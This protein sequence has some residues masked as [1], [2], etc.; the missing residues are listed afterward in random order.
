[1]VTESWN[2]GLAVGRSGGRAFVVQAEAPVAEVDLATFQVRSHP[3]GPGAL[4]ADAVA[5]PEREALWLGGGL[6]AVTGLDLQSSADEPEIRETP[7]GLT[8]VDT[9]RWRART[10]DPRTTDA[11]LVSGTLLASSFFFDSRRQTTSR[12]GLTGCSVDGSR[13]FH[14]YGNAPI[15]GVQPL[16]SKALVGVQ[17]GT[18]LIDARTGR[19]LRRYPRFTVSLLSGDAPVSY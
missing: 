9:R 17:D 7:A 18:V 6:L 3:L 4:A 2:P 5:G 16:G 19:Q 11:A 14:L 8:L 15:T 12:S 1:M 10:I 13:K